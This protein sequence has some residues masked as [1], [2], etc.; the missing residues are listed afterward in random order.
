MT[1]QSREMILSRK[2]F[3]DIEMNVLK[4]ETCNSFGFAA[5]ADVVTSDADQQLFI[6]RKFNKLAARNILGLQNELKYLE[7][8]LEE[9]DH[10]V[11]YSSDRILCQ[12]MRSY[13]DFREN[14]KSQSGLQIRQN[15]HDDI[16]RK[17]S[18][19]CE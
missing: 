3:M 19:Y 6:F 1:S 16:D 7:R 12:S 10:E 9:L 11:E 8:Q 4:D 14:I 17:L 2:F 18:R 13:D 15:L 5:V